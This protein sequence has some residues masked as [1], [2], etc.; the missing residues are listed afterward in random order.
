MS[1]DFPLESDR[2]FIAGLPLER[3]LH[4]GSP[5]F[6]KKKGKYYEK[7]IMYNSN[8]NYF[9]YAKFNICLGAFFYHES[10]W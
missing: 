3:Y 9:S 7:K 1:T 10:N 4:S 8:N 6:F 5:V 2:H